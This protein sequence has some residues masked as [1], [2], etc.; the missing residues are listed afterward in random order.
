MR[1]GKVLY[2]WVAVM[3]SCEGPFVVLVSGST[4][5]EARR[6]VFARYG[7]GTQILG[8]RRSVRIS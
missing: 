1:Q 7:K 4:D 5:S 2:A 6:A 8:L 3:D